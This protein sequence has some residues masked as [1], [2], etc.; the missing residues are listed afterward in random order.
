MS[1]MRLSVN[2]KIDQKGVFGVGVAIERR[3]GGTKP[4]AV[5]VIV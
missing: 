3:R 4:A 1:A 5:Q 2:R